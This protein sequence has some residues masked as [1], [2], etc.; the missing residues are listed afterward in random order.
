MKADKA[1]IR[2]RVDDLLRVILDGAQ[3]WDIRRYVSERQAAGEPPWTLA[4]GAKPLSERQI[5]RYC[6][7]ADKWMAR[8]SRTHR[9]KLFRR[10]V[11]RRESLYGRAVAAGQ[12]N[13]AL[14]VLRDLAEFQG[15]YP[16]AD[17]LLRRE[18]E[19]LRKQLAERKEA[20]REGDNGTAAEGTGGAGERGEGPPQPAP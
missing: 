1:T 5:R 12:L 7:V 2:A 10:H 16:S 13:V 15:L 3:P 4:E 6:D 17:D 9:H 14:A 11:A 18:A 8:A 20:R 19:A